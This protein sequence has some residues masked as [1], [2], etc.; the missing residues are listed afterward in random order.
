[1][2]ELVGRLAAEAG[3]DRDVAAKAVGIMLAFLL[4]EGPADKVKPLLDLIPGAE[5][6]AQEQSGNL[7]MGG[8]MGAGM[9]LM[10]LGL[11]MPEVQTVSR[12]VMGY[13]REKAGEDAVGEIVNA[14]PGLGQFV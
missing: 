9:A 6:A 1:M 4:R 2:D 10:S 8:V 3:I 13:A 5:A 7:G 12:L 11:S 14:I